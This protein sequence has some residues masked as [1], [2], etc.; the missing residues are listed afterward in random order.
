M[1]CGNIFMIRTMAEDLC[2]NCAQFHGYYITEFSHKV[3]YSIYIIINPITILN[4]NNRFNHVWEVFQHIIPIQIT[5]E[6]KVL[7]NWGV[8]LESVLR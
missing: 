6:M 2:S 3:P 7:K 8:Y 5:T 4:L 1:K